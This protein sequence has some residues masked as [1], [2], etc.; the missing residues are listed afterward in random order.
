MTA[1]Q[2]PA[3]GPQVGYIM[4]LTRQ[5]KGLLEDG[6]EIADKLVNAAEGEISKQEASDLIEALI[7][8]VNKMGGKTGNVRPI[9]R[10]AYNPYREEEEEADREQAKWEQ[11]RTEDC[12]RRDVYRAEQLRQFGGLNERPAP[13]GGSYL[14]VWKK[15]P[16]AMSPQSWGSQ[17]ETGWRWECR[18]PSHQ[19]KRG[20]HDVVSGGSQRGRHFTMIN[21]FAHLKKFHEEEEPDATTNHAT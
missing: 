6:D 3:T 21:A 5:L 10:V 19:G 2:A 14:K 13:E 12:T 11:M 7:G 18:H 4:S 8:A 1:R 9:R 16:N 20:G 17:I 15:F